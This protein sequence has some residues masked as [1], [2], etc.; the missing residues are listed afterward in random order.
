MADVSVFSVS[1]GGN[2]AIATAEIAAA[3]QTQIEPEEAE[4]PKQRE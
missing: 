2:D 4:N 1:G 3:A